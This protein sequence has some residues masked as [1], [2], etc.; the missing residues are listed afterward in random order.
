MNPT[1]LV[2]SLSDYG[3]SFDPDQISSP[4]VQAPLHQRE[5]GGLGLFF[6]RHWMDEI[7]FDVV[8]DPQLGRQRN[9]LTMIKKKQSVQG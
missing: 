3:R 7:H 5:K 8:K 6:M 1:N 9:V 2:I 4:P